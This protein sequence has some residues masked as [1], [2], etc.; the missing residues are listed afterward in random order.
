MNATE[1]AQAT[2]LLCPRHGASTVT[3]TEHCNSDETLRCAAC[4]YECPNYLKYPVTEVTELGSGRRYA[5]NVIT[6]KRVCPEPG[7]DPA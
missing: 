1:R 4:G 7:M 6:G 2:H 5:M 3:L